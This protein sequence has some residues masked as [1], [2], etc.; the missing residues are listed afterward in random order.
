MKNEKEYA[1]IM[2]MFRYFYQDKWASE[3]IFKGKSR[4][5]ISAFNDLIAQ[6]FIEKRKKYPGFEYRW[7]AAFPHEY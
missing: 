7:A 1:E 5:W 4:A 6:G 2:H 3:N